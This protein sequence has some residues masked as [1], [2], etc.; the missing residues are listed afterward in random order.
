MSLS[1]QIFLWIHMAI[2]LYGL[3]LIARA[4]DAR[5][6]FARF[7]QSDAIKT[8]GGVRFLIV[9]PVLRE[10]ELVQEAMA[11]FAQLDY[12]PENYRIVFVTSQR[13]D[14]EPH[15]GYD[16]TT[17]DV[18]ERGLRESGEVIR[19]IVRNVH[20]PYK[21][22]LMAD[23]VN[24]AVRYIFEAYEGYC[25]E[26]NTFVAVYNIDSRPDLAVLREVANRF[27]SEGHTVF[28]QLS[29]YTPMHRNRVG[30]FALAVGWAFAIWQ[31]RW[32][33][34]VEM[35][36]YNKSAAIFDA[37]E[38][39]QLQK[40]LS[41]PEHSKLLLRTPFS[42]TIGHGLFVRLREFITLN[43]LP[44]QRPNEDA[45]FG[46]ALPFHGLTPRPLHT[47]DR[48]ESCV[49]LKANLRQQ[50]TWIIGPG[51]APVYYRYIVPHLRTPRSTVY[52][53]LYTCRALTDAIVWVVGPALFVAFLCVLGVA[54]FGG[55]APQASVLWLAGLVWVLY[56]Y[57]PTLLTVQ[58]EAVA[59]GGPPKVNWNR[60]SIV[61][62]ALLPLCYIVHGVGG[63]IGVVRLLGAVFMKRNY[64]QLKIKT[65]R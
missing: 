26:L 51:L 7:Y 58:V 43:Y 14:V 59:R 47:L 11:Y 12:P 20:Y 4:I 31:T 5:R 3:M 29:I 27:N 42:Y 22:G 65:E 64:L 49:G 19:K 48:S 28:Q 56:F 13:E 18:I 50:A 24:Y 46:F 32:S 6:L 15:P 1:I 45:E 8:G 17:K 63:V 57:V 30:F 25:D 23:Q 21:Q 2:G 44:T 62:C 52:G 40:Q 41:A 53:W 10:Q 38:Q 9:V 60:Y 36:R 54:A 34:V 33:F 61:G 39:G 16:E 55:P 37:A 35:P